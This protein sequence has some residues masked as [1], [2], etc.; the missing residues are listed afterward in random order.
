MSKKEK[1]IIKKIKLNVDIIDEFEKQ[2]KILM[3]RIINDDFIETDDKSS[4]EWM[5]YEMI[6]KL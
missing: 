4:Y 2:L 6:Y 1:G 3:L 5:D